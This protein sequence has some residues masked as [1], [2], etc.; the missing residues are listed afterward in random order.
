MVRKWSHITDLPDNWTSLASAELKSIASIWKDQ[1]G[2]LI[3]LDSIKHFN[4]RLAREWAIE[5][6]VIENIYH[7][8]GGVTIVLIEKGIEANFIPHGASDRPAEEVVQIVRDHQTALEGLFAF[9]KHE[10]T[11][12]NSYI[13]ALHEQMLKHQYF[14]IGKNTLGQTVEIELKRGQFKVLPNNP[15]IPGVG[16]HEYCPPEHVQSEMDNLVKWHLIHLKNKVP[17]E[18]EA[19]WLH[20]R[21][22]QIH[23]FQD[24]NGRIARALASLVFIREG[25]FPLVITRDTRAEY[26][27]SLGAADNGNLAPLANMFARL[28]KASLLKALSL[29]ED[30][31]RRNNMLNNVVDAA[32][33][34][35]RQRREDVTA[36]QRKVI[37]H[38]R[39]LEEVCA[40]TMEPLAKNLTVQLRTLNT[41]YGAT[42][43]RSDTLKDFWFKGQI[44]TVAKKL[45]YFADTITHRAWVRLKIV[46]ERQTFLVVSFH[47]VGTQFVGIL[48][49]SAFV[50]F[51]ERD[52]EEHTPIDGPYP[53]SA[54]L[55]QFSYLDKFDAI[56]ERFTRWL[57][58]SLAT[59]LDQWRRQI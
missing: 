38:A 1:H 52:S 18:L 19:A 25:Y 15:S 5:T 32:I 8:D 34:R 23:P 9:V 27:E 45:D 33:D 7:I 44:V 43:D 53:V 22:T 14:T 16:L 11:I 2:R 39:K 20:H 50:E 51:R 59:G 40:E 37:E 57:D 17:A 24:G 26:I 30:V 4:E 55:F 31:I 29:S 56:R 21:F 58:E 42:V 49:I 35:L 41:V 36:D 3:K 10:R 13:C 6:G 28:Q 47:S 48:G 54:D 46:D 12:S